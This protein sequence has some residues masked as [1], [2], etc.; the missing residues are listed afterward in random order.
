[1]D[2]LSRKHT[3]SFWVQSTLHKSLGQGVLDLHWNNASKD[4]M[5]ELLKLPTEDH[6]AKHRAD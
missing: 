6:V 4:T 1:M 3:Q 5:S 2:I